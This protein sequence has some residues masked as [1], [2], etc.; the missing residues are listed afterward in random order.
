MSSRLEEEFI[1]GH[2]YMFL[3]YSPQACLLSERINLKYIW[4]DIVHL[5]GPIGAGPVLP[6]LIQSVAGGLSG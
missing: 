6:I 3:E 5:S 1:S 4:H 2:V